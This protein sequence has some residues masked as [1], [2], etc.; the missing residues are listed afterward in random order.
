MQVFLFLLEAISTIANSHRETFF[1]E[2]IFS[3]YMKMKSPRRFA[4]NND[5]IY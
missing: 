1:V 5:F 3:S 4:P 2:T